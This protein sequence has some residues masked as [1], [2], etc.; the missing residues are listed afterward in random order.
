MKRAG[1]IILIIGLGFAFFLSSGWSQDILKEQKVTSEGVGV[2]INDDKALARDNAIEDALRKA[3]EQAVG[4]MI[5]SETM[6]ENFQLLSDTVYQRSQGYVSTYRIVSE[7][8]EENLYRVTIQATVALDNLKSDLGAIGLIIKRKGKPRV[9]V[10]MAEQN[11]GREHL[12]FWWGGVA[13]H[14]S[15]QSDMGISEN[16]IIDQFTQ[17]GFHF[18][19]RNVVAK[20][21]WT[22]SAFHHAD[23]SDR[24]V[25]VL[26]DQSGAEVVIIGKATARLMGNV[27]DTSMS[28]CQASASARVV[29]TDTGEIIATAMASA[30]AVHID[31]VTAGNEALKKAS[32]N[33]A[34]ELEEKILKKWAEEA[35]NTTMIQLTISGVSNYKVFQSLKRVL[36]NETRGVE[37][38]YQRKLA[39]GVVTL[40]VEM[41]GTAQM[42]ADD[43]GSRKFPDFSIDINEITHNA[44]KLTLFPK[45]E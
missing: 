1:I 9:M 21:I 20:D 12:V 26:G 18:V 40:D 45:V 15:N 7:G 24:E 41:Q 8:T 10:M 5:D 32:E 13:G 33:L 3:V 25:Q 42:L 34:L 4:T 27:M 37:A 17:S 6:V 36:S 31:V 22:Q 38:V 19:D 14:W 2:V 43:L 44:I 30:P 39:A 16:T 28:S 11:I 29:K 35:A 23:L